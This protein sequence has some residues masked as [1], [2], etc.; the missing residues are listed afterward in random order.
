MSR[1]LVLN[2]LEVDICR[3][4]DLCEYH[5]SDITP[6]KKGNIYVN[7]TQVLI[8]KV[9]EHDC[10]RKDVQNSPTHDIIENSSIQPYSLR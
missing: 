3:L 5:S 10:K 4:F 6:I 9:H 8:F 2:A 7:M 1:R